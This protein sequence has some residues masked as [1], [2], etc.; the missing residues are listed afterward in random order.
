MPD[1]AAEVARQDGIDN[2]GKRY[3]IPHRIVSALRPSCRHEDPDNR[4]GRMIRWSHV[5][6]RAGSNDLTGTERAATAV[7]KAPVV[8][9]TFRA[10]TAH[11][12][13]DRS[14]AITFGSYAVRGESSKW[15]AVPPP[16]L[17]GQLVRLF[18]TRGNTT[19][20]KSEDE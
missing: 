16:R 14:G 1:S 4:S 12:F 10:V 6:C 9:R 7:P 13:G 2:I 5:R 18:E 15:N 17:S 20:I 3:G 19:F 11:N 8:R